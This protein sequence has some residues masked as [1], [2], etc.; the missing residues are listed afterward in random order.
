MG[1]LESFILHC[2]LPDTGKTRI[3]YGTVFIP[4]FPRRRDK[5][6]KPYGLTRHRQNTVMR[7][8]L[9]D[10]NNGLRRNIRSTPSM[11]VFF[12]ALC[13]GQHRVSAQSRYSDRL[14]TRLRAKDGVRIGPRLYHHVYACA[15]L[16]RAHC[17]SS[18]GEIFF[19]FFWFKQW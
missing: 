19:F 11:Y 17:F 5:H 18:V 3:E 8:I 2:G 4:Y 13:R 7:L 14:S 16:E 10:P 12:P 1:I 9:T 15:I 6:G